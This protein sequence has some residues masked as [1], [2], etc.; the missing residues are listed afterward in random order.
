MS[1]KK[2]NIPTL[3]TGHMRKIRSDSINAKNMNFNFSHWDNYECLP[4][5]LKLP[6]LSPWHFAPYPK[7]HYLPR[8][9]PR[10]PSLRA[11]SPA[12]QV[13]MRRWWSEV[14]CFRIIVFTRDCADCK[15]KSFSATALSVLA[16]L[17]GEFLRLLLKG[18]RCGNF[19]GNFVM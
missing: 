14:K 7:P 10:S 4:L 3:L 2:L 16:V 11:S 12:R 18:Y 8:P 19:Q 13:V 9:R 1:P 5:Q 15:M 17:T 6:I